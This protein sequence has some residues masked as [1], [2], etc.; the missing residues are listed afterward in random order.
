M[1]LTYKIITGAAAAL[2][3][4]AAGVVYAHQGGGM[5]GYGPGYGMGGMG[6]GMAGAMGGGMGMGMGYGMAGGMFGVNDGA[7][8]DLKAELK[9]TPAQEATWLAFEN[10]TKQQSA[11]MLALGSQMHNPQPGAT[12]ADFAAQRNAMMALRDAN[13]AARETAV[14]D[15]YA[16]LTPEQK[17]VADHRLNAMGGH[18]SAR[19]FRAN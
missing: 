13:Q 17:A 3:L 4:A 2:S 6:Y 10:L 14:K 12:S 7:M 19:N 15:L 16:V 11:A 9:I 8:A 1:K 5:G 18:R